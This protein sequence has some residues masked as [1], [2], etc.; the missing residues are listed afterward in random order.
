[1]GAHD[2][3]GPAPSRHGRKLSKLGPGIIDAEQLDALLRADQRV[4][5]FPGCLKWD[6]RERMVMLAGGAWLCE[7]HAKDEGGEG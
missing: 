4:C 7:N 3:H 2:F 5:E 1:V 6:H